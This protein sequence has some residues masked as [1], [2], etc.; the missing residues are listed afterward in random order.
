MV[1]AVRAK[2]PTPD[3]FPMR[4]D[5]EYRIMEGKYVRKAKAE[6]KIICTICMHQDYYREDASGHRV[7]ELKSY[8]EYTDQGQFTEVSSHVTRHTHRLTGITTT[9]LWI[10]Y[11]CP[12]NHA[13]SVQLNEAQ[14]K[15]LTP[16]QREKYIV[17]ES[18]PLP[19]KLRK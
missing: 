15:L 6:G 8:E 3:E 7:G 10:D 2:E 16:A 1:F 9:S 17:E 14:I 5:K 18:V 11:K 13:V 4:V 19:L 12:R